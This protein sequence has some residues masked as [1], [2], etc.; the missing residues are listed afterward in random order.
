VTTQNGSYVL[1]KKP[2]GRL[3]KGAHAV[4]REFRVMH[5]LWKVAFPVP[6]PLALCLDDAVIG[7]PF[8]IMEMVS[9]RIFWDSSLPTAGARQRGALFEA[10][11]ST[12]ARLHMLTP[13]TIGLGGFGRAERYLQRQIDRWS[14]QYLGDGGEFGDKHMNRLI[15]WLPANVPASNDARVVHGDYRIDN[16]IFH[17]TEAAVVAV[18]DWELST[19]G[20]P[21]AD[22]TY[23]LMMYRLPPDIVGGLAGNDLQLLGIPTEREYVEAYCRRT[24]Q[25]HI[26]G[27]D[28]YLAF[29]LFRFAAILYGIKSRIRHG[30]AASS[31][32]TKTA[33][34]ASTVAELAWR[35]VSGQ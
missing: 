14:Q 2:N 25:S 27:L 35:Q 8:Y 33:M 26:G 31:N 28:F 32:A 16:L 11:N 4:E 10:M 7:T 3:L 13:Q 19:L 34:H 12:L 21:L 20:D 1:R 18:L 6:R 24:G 23:H 29:N 17:P 9:G 30:T 5:A 15:D 22:F